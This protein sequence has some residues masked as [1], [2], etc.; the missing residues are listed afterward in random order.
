MAIL[1][2]ES[3][4]MFNPL[5]SEMN[6]G[7]C[8]Q[9]RRQ[10]SCESKSV[11]RPLSPVAAAKA[12]GIDIW[13]ERHEHI[14]K[15]VWDIQKDELVDNIDVRKVIFITHKWRLPG[16]TAEV[17]YQD[18]MK[19]QGTNGQA[20]GVGD[21]SEKLDRIKT[22]LLKHT[23]Y[24][25]IDTICIDKSNLSELDE[26]IRSMYK[27]YANC[28]AVVL[29]SDTTLKEWRT[30]GW[31]LQ[32]GG[33]AGILCGIRRKRGIVTIQH[34]AAE[35]NQDLCTLDL[36]LYYRPGNAAEILA[37]M[38]VRKTTRTEDMAYALAGVFSIHLTLAYGEGIKSR[39]RLLHELAI[40]GG[41]ISFLSFQS[42][43]I[44]ERQYCLPF[45]GQRVFSIAHCA[46]SSIPV[47][48]SPLGICF[49]AQLIRGLDARNVVRKLSVW[50]HLNF[51]KCRSV[52]IEGLI[53]AAKM[54]ERQRTIAIELAIVHEIKSLL[55]VHIYNNDLLGNDGTPM[56][57]CYRLQCC[58][59]EENEF[60]RLFD[61]TKATVERV[62][63]GDRP[64]DAKEVVAEQ[65]LFP[66]TRR[67]WP[68]EF[69]KFH[70]QI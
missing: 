60:G 70:T 38:D 11:H 18:V 39:E 29:D 14:V 20:I 59:I 8:A 19:R 31:C 53:M 28:A 45:I 44:M 57:L 46:K 36:H 12:V 17:T 56:K 43:E 54:L 35:Q 30:R 55:L 50:K 34:L 26:A 61:E 64:N 52:G 5:P 24:V 65:R 49:E 51:A 40:Q 1:N 66:W 3:D 23:Q 48:V 15:R 27:W 41:D 22:A 4:P 32:E 62:W 33:S 68:T 37:R 10:C 47:S 6:T 9:N 21:T 2:L 13:R 67:R 63:L 42:T 7:W 58:Q 69:V 16:V 25:W